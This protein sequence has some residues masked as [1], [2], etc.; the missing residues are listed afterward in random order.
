MALTGAI[1]SCFICLLILNDFLIE[2]ATLRREHVSRLA[3]LS[4]LLHVPLLWLYGA[5]FLLTVVFAS[6]AEPL[7]SYTGW[8]PF[9]LLLVWMS[10]LLVVAKWV[11]ARHD[12][13]QN[14]DLKPKPP[15]RGND[16]G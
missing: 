6:T 3:W 15:S 1:A 10:L 4:Q 12:T 9:A 13:V 14:G 2:A 16:H 11:T 7:A 8:F 5:A